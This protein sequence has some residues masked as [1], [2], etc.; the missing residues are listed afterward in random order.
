MAGLLR[1][2]CS[3][4]LRQLGDAASHGSRTLDATTSHDAAVACRPPG[5]RAP[6]GAAR[7]TRRSGSCQAELET[8]GQSCHSPCAYEVAP[9]SWVQDCPKLAAR[10]RAAEEGSGAVHAGRELQAT[11][12][13]KRQLAF[14]PTSQTCTCI[15]SDMC[16]LCLPSFLAVCLAVPDSAART[17]FGATSQSPPRPHMIRIRNR[18]PPAASHRQAHEDLWTGATNML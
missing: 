13:S 7:E 4:P 2:S 3:H 8:Q 6:C 1:C 14:V 16:S 9:A 18:T 17:A 10:R 11:R 15:E 12:G 5:C